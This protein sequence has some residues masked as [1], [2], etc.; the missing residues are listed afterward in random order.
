MTDEQESVES[1]KEWILTNTQ[2]AEKMIGYREA[3]ESIAKYGQGRDKEIARR[4]LG[5]GED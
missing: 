4:A 5:V 2:Q 1:F 3:L